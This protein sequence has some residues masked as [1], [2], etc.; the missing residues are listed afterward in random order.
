MDV[1]LINPFIKA[2][3]NV[4]ETMAFI[5]PKP[6]KPYIK[7]DS[8][9]KGDVSSVIGLSGETRGTISITFTKPCILSIVSNMFGETMSTL[10]NEVMD[11]VGEIANMISGQAR[12]A[13]ESA[14]KVLYAAVPTMIKGKDHT[15]SHRTTAAIMAVPFKTEYGAFTIEVCFED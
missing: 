6:Q 13:L 14:G 11:A 9:A 4:L 2:T 7:K 10:D 8:V 5:K 1:Q 3:I 12:Q 15:I